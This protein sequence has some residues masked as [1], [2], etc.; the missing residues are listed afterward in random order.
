MINQTK[1]IIIN[2]IL[3]FI[4][5]FVDICIMNFLNI[6]QLLGEKGISGKEL[7]E[8]VNVTENAISLIING[9]RQPRFELLKQIADYLEVPFERLFKTDDRY[10]DLY[11]VDENGTFIFIGR[12]DL[13][14]IKK[15]TDK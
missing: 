11:T 3:C 9:K 10:N 8:A 5:V 2:K 6:K 13:N 1:K 14:E 4:V 15:L 12:V 7:A